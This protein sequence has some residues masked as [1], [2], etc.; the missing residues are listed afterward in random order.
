MVVF[1]CT[2]TESTMRSPPRAAKLA[3]EPKS[4]ETAAEAKGAAR[5]VYLGGQGHDLRIGWKGPQD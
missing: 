5:T 1:S 3:G 2:S 4:D